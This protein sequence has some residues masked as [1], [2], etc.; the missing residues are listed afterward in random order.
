VNATLEDGG[1]AIAEIPRE[2]NCF[3]EGE[4]VWIHWDP[5]NEVRFE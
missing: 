3:R 2:Q 5:A 1:R 4:T